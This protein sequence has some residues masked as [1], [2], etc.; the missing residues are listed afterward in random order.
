M[1]TSLDSIADIEAVQCEI[2]W[3]HY[4]HIVLNQSLEMSSLLQGVGNFIIL[5]FKNKF[6]PK[7]H[8]VLNAW[9]ECYTEADR[10][11]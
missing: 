2:V 8:L 6:R 9:A 5:L 1:I 11:N 10:K 4:M 3:S 7:W